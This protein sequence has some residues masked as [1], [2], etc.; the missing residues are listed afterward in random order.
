MLKSRETSARKCWEEPPGRDSQNHF[1]GLLIAQLARNDDF[2]LSAITGAEIIEDC[3][4][5]IRLARDYIGGRA[6]YLDCRGELID[7]YMNHGYS[8]LKAKP[9]TNGLY[10]MVKVPPRI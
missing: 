1:G 7:F 2:P 3:E 9:F 4:E 8:L 6:I 5:I 10:K